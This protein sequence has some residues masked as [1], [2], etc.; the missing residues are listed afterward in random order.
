MRT[1]WKPSELLEA[2]ATAS[3]WHKAKAQSATQD[4]IKRIIEHFPVR[5]GFLWLRR[6]SRTEAEAMEF[7]KGD[8]SGMFDEYWMTMHHHRNGVDKW[9]SIHKAC[10]TRCDMIELSHD[11]SA[12]ISSFVGD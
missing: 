9:K 12:F 10:Q 11:E 6:R 8:Y 4:E 5:Y 3:D 1:H 2:S 7:I